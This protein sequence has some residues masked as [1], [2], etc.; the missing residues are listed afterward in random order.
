MISVMIFMQLYHEMFLILF[1]NPNKSYEFYV[2]HD[3][4]VFILRAVANITHIYF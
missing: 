4:S 2:V 3:I 1:A